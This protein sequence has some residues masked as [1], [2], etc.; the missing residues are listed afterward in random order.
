MRVDLL[1]EKGLLNSAPFVK[2]EAPPLPMVD[3]EIPEEISEDERI[4]ETMARRQR[5]RVEAKQDPEKGE[6]ET[7]LEE[8]LDDSELDDEVKEAVKRAVDTGKPRKK[9]RSKAKQQV[10]VRDPAVVAIGIFVIL[11][12]FYYFIYGGGYLDTAIR[13]VNQTLKIELIKPALPLRKPV[14]VIETT[15]PEPAVQPEQRQSDYLSEEEFN[16]LMPVTESIAALKDSISQL[17]MTAA[18]ETQENVAETVADQTD[19]EDQ[20]KP[21]SEMAEIT[22]PKSEVEKPVEEERAEPVIQRAQPT[23]GI[24]LSDQDVQLLNNH[25]MLLVM[26]N[27]LSKS[28][29]RNEAS[30]I[31]I[32]RSSIEITARESSARM[33]AELEPTIEELAIADIKVSDRTVSSSLEYILQPVSEFNVDDRDLLGVFDLLLHPYDTELKEINLDVDQGLQN[34]PARIVFQ[35]NATRIDRILGGWAQVNTNYLLQDL[36]LVK[37]GSLYTLT[38]NIRL[39]QY[40][41]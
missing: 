21:E 8:K 38:I 2:G 35:S 31:F 36:E 3:T 18:S 30:R 39:I 15:T 1:T 28:S 9:K 23:P 7:V 37:Q 32:S 12:A 13:W 19:T 4:A 25:A 27:A 6:A 29:I 41:S 22:D 20:Q 10:K 33:M 16:A 17:D 14:A 26:K 5:A 24:N 34:N 40:T 11:A